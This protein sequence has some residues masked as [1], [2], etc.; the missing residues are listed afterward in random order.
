MDLLRLENLDVIDFKEN[1]IDY[2]IKVQTKKC[3]DII[4]PNMK[5]GSINFVKNGTKKNQFFWDI[6]ISGKRVCLV[7]DRQKY[8]CKECGATWLEELYEIDNGRKMT[9]RLI[10]Y[11]EEKSIYKNCTFVSLADE[12]GVTEPTV[13][14][15][16]NDIVRKFERRFNPKTP[17][18]LGI[19]EI[20]ILGS[21]KS[22]ITNV[23]ENTVIDILKDRKQATI[24]EYLRKIPNKEDIK[25]VTMDM[26]NPYK[27][28]VKT[29]LPNVKI[30]VDTFHVV[31]MANECLENVRKELRSTLTSTQRKVLKNE[32]YVLLKRRHDL[33]SH[34]TINMEAWTKLFPIIGEAYELKEAFCSV[35]D[36]ED[37]N[38]AK[39]ALEAWVR[40]I[41]DNVKQ[42]FKPLNTALGN[43]N[44]ELFNY[45]DYKVI[46]DYTESINTIT[47][48]T[49]RIG[50][51]Y[52]F[53]VIRAKFLYSRGIRKPCKPNDL[54]SEPINIFGGK[55]DYGADISIILQKLQDGN[56]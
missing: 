24:I 19:N 34:E 9:Y 11:I 32:R 41:P 39:L 12:I 49:D 45:Y 51:G 8:K 42:A 4:C 3:T 50:R 35:W 48:Q 33:T 25:L 47:S 15:V 29:V 17:V 55:D 53:D 28:S 21:S 6:P 27:T 56:L 38:T 5:C 23:K 46:K 2:V 13:K 22:V 43:W 10:D 16:F 31:K 52:S 54:I 20:N 7:I 14:N 40:S 1:D 44:E 30:V 18:W 26:W 37:K 36:I